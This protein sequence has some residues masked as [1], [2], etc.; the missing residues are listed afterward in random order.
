MEVSYNTYNYPK[1]F[2]ED[3][4]IAICAYLNRIHPITSITLSNG[5]ICMNTR[6]IKTGLRVLY[7][8]NNKIIYSKTHPKTY[9]VLDTDKLIVKKVLNR[10]KLSLPN[11]IPITKKVLLSSIRYKGDKLTMYSYNEITSII[12]NIN[13]YIQIVTDKG[14]IKPD[15][16]IF[17]MLSDKIRELDRLITLYPYKESNYILKEK[18]MYLMINRDNS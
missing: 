9:L 7:Y 5:Y 12:I 18:I 17:N 6:L 4:Y 3:I 15:I 10:M 2:E 11:D 14:M 1:I 8:K 16:R 13:K